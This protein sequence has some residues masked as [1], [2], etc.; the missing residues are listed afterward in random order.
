[1]DLLPEVARTPG[2]ALTIIGDGARREALETLFAGTDTYF[3][4]YL[5]GDDL[6]QAFASA[7]VF[8]FTGPNETFGQVV[9]EAMASGLPAVVTQQGAV[10]DLVLP[11]ET[12]YICAEDPAGF[13]AAIIRLRDQPALR[14]QIAFKSRQLAAQR[15]WETV[16]S[17]LETHYAE[18]VGLNERLLR[19][20]PPAEG[21]SLASLFNRGQWP[22]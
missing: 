22:L 10:A 1:V 19:L 5:V 7:D 11:G 14:E 3:T 16:L 6:P 2:V 12:G 9:Q 20:Y 21:L 8:V 17:Q 18:A 4:G 15:P 13:A